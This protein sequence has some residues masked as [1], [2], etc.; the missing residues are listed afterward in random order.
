MDILRS[1][2][3]THR[4]A[5][6]VAAIMV[7]IITI[8]LLLLDAQ[9]RK[10]PKLDAWHV[11]WLSSEFRER[12]T[13]TVADLTGYL[14][15]E[16]VVFQ[17]LEKFI[18]ESGGQGR[19][20]GWTRYSPDGISNSGNFAVNW[21]R[22][23]VL[24]P[25]GRVRGAALLLHGLT[26]S[27][28][29]LRLTGAALSEQGY[30]VVGLRLPGHG[31]IPGA[32]AQV[33]WQDWSAAVQLAARHVALLAGEQSFV[34]VG[35][36][37]GGALALD[38]SLSALKDEALRTPDQVVLI[39]PAVGIVRYARF[40]TLPRWISKLKCWRAMAWQSVALE[41]DPYKYNSFPYNGAL[42]THRLTKHVDERLE[43]MDARGELATMPPILTFASL[44]D[45]TVLVEDI[46]SRLYA[47]MPD[48]GSEL[49]IYDMNRAAEVDQ[50]YKQ[51]PVQRMV[52]LL[53][54][55]RRDYTL[56]AL[57]D[58][59]QQDQAIAEI[60]ARPGRVQPEPAVSTGL[61]WP[62]DV[63][64]LSHI[65]LPFSPDDPLYGRGDGT[66]GGRMMLGSLTPRGERGVLRVPAD[67][68]L[69]LRCNPF[70]EYQQKK[71]RATLAGLQ[72]E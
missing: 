21:N 26:D 38:Y 22:T 34:I 23:Y 61:T 4:R 18:K 29:S 66:S 35:Y 64:S 57:T 69:R 44:V 62:S 52:D 40:A 16:D 30:H 1:V 46:V 68:F 39:S 67:Y 42:Q 9:V 41:F 5:L 53:D 60:S 59:K 37:N 6:K 65:A 54:A 32:L 70:F 7:A 24:E 3:I 12:D 25:K 50:F 56:T 33:Q 2:N 15:R 63:Y 58:A 13:E 48:N 55:K 27:P 43:R 51:D 10:K 11:E 36:S 45:A 72:A 19:A 31:T 71:I 14:T 28:Y 49:V 8:A 17:E 47:R 20:D